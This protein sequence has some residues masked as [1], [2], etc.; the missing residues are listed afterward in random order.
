MATQASTINKLLSVLE[1]QQRLIEKQ[2][3]IIAEQTE[4]I[5]AASSNASTKLLD[6]TTNKVKEP[7]IKEPSVKVK[8][9]VSAAVSFESKPEIK[10]KVKP[11]VEYKPEIE[12]GLGLET[13]T[14]AITPQVEINPYNLIREQVDLWRTIDEATGVA[15]S[16]AL[17]SMLG[18][19]VENISD[20]NGN[21]S[22]TIEDVEVLTTNAGSDIN[23]AA[24]LRAIPESSDRSN[25]GV[26]EGLPKESVIISTYQWG[27]GPDPNLYRE[28]Y[29]DG[30]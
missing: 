5:W 7:N 15:G 4:K 9:D 16:A 2:S 14:E 23:Q 22:E 3:T 29:A 10:S 11:Q 30:H 19:Q 21:S 27:Y 1:S 20:S 17:G 13:E 28:G 8:S 24:K 26:T 12:F 25:P 6:V 18:A